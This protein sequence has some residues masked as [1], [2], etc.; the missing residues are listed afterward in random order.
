[1]MRLS[2]YIPLC[3]ANM[4]TLSLATDLAEFCRGDVEDIAKRGALAN[5]AK[6][7][8]SLDAIEAE[9]RCEPVRSGPPALRV[10]R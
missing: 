7:R 6:M 8:A 3:D 9:L 1:M 10:V 4:A 2:L 5:I